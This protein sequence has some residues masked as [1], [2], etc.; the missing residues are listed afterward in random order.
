MKLLSILLLSLFLSSPI[1]AQG[2]ENGD[3]E[4][5][6]TTFHWPDG[7]KMAISLT[8]DDARL[9]QIDKGLSIL[10]S[11]G[12]KATFYLSPENMM[13]RVDGWKEAV[14]NGHDMGNHS[15]EHPCTVNF[16]WSR[17]TALEDYT[18]KK[19]S[20]E[21]DS[22]S[23][24]I[25]D[26]LGVT[27]TSFGYP[28]G[29]TYVGRGDQT[30]SYVP[31]VSAMFETGRT[32][33][34]EGPNDPVYCDFAQL[35]G[36]E[37]D[38]KSFE[39]ILKLIDAARESGSW[40]VLAG[41]EMDNG[42]AQTSLLSTID[43]LCSY[44]SDP[45][46][47][48]WIDHVTHVGRYVS[49]QRGIP[50]HTEMLPYMNPV[51]T[52]DERVDDLISRMSLEEKIG[53]LNM[54]CVYFSELGRTIEEKMEG[55]RKF[56][57]GTFMEGIG[58]GG[59]F[60]TLANQ[61]L[62]EGP[63]QQA[64]YYNELQKIAIEQTR[65]GI[66]L[67]QTEEGTHGLMCSGGTIFPE[68]PALGSTWN[69]DLMSKVY[70][71][72]A[73]EARAL[74]IHQLFTLVIEPNRDPRLGRNQ[75]GYG[76]DPYLCSRI[77]ETIVR[78][79]QG[80][81]L[82]AKDKV[83]AGL[84]H[85]PGQS[86]PASGLERGAMEISERT[87]R[88][89][90]LPP[91]EAGIKKAGAL[92]VM[93][94][95]PTIDGIPAHASGEILT[96]I[97]RGELGFEGLVLSEG[98]GVNTLVYTG[99]AENIKDAGAMAANA[100][101]DVSI[102]FGQGYFNEMIE[103][104]KEGKV[105]METI[106]RSVRRVLEL[107]YQLGLFENPF[108]D[109]AQA[110]EVSHTETNQQLALEAA[111]QGLVLLKNEDGLLP[112]GKKISSIA[113]I[114]PNADDE[115]NQLG[116]YTS[117]VVLQ[118][119]VTVLDGIKS[120]VDR[121]TKV[122]YVKGCNVIGEDVDEINEAVKAAETSDIAVVVLG[123]NEWQK[124]QK[125]GTSGEGYDVATLEL[126]GKQK[127]L[128]Q[129]VFETGTPTMVVL[130]NGRPLAIPWIEN[131]IPVIL[132]A[133]IPGEKGGEAVAEVLFGDCNPSGKLTL[134]IP[135]HAGQLPVFY[136]HKPSKSYWLKEGWGNSYAD[137]DHRPLFSFGFGLSY[138]KFE[139][140]NLNISPERSGSQGA[141]SVSADITNI[142]DVAG[143]EIVQLYIRDRISSVVRPVKELKGFERI[144]LEPGESKQVI[145][146]LGPDQLKM[147]NGDLHWTV[148]PGEFS[149][150]IGTSSDDIRL[151]GSLWID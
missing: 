113:V 138:S 134:T 11:Y 124:E 17:Q 96:E 71:T 146:E 88:D 61:I 15:I 112:L 82:S 20:I 8:F 4:R 69:M 47:G 120:K 116:D 99:V 103:N 145:F 51:L 60:F 98:G 70:E 42:G 128:I 48:I 85:Y 94:T 52:V 22:A 35:T 25:R 107:K 91:W 104:V 100:G 43:S 18:L 110:L 67:L 50:P 83:V 14:S 79:V 109:P 65:L 34:D 41:H 121:N 97:L 62:H 1:L 123:E 119:V 75:E 27:P 58:P 29:Q 150:M 9:S 122:R 10:D 2:Y 147:L 37:L 86:Q 130:I 73:R 106:D 149:I 49:K 139:Y 32:W 148:E 135:R 7:K 129:R 23:R 39:D 59:G 108:V 40:L 80:H 132:E 68:G 36:M 33:L 24:L 137:L 133:W 19:M 55:C 77:A 57:N 127:E 93:A 114:G 117:N 21:L 56:A 143:A 28:C 87:L 111:R 131:N 84:C 115:K 12:V 44:A 74:G 102:S 118:D 136:N 144:P 89:L 3:P 6:R 46:N 105:S 78:A 126:T 101:M 66:P 31:L 72:A 16:Y 13:Q 81:D 142:S 38:G 30:Q 92:G 95:Y 26:L 141:F 64:A 45:E 5:T 54:P 53:Q 90:F 151:S 63:A 76:E 125:A 140:S